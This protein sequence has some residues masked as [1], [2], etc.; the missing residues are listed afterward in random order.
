L[1]TRKCS[2]CGKYQRKPQAKITIERK[3]FNDAPLTIYDQIKMQSKCIKI[4]E[5]VIKALH[6]QNTTEELPTWI[7][8]LNRAQHT[9]QELITTRTKY[10]TDTKKR[11]NVTEL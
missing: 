8:T 3:Q 2:Q 11:K 4:T 7:K 6:Q 5:N 9:L 10:F 1:N